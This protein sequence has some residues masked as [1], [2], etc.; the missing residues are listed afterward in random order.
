[1]DRLWIRAARGRGCAHCER[2][3]P[4][5]DIETAGRRIKFSLCLECV[6]VWF[7]GKDVAWWED[8]H[9]PFADHVVAAIQR[10]AAREFEELMKSTKGAPWKSTE[11]VAV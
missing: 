7:P 3:Q 5:E 1:M 10:A 11:K 8:H 6:L 2:G 9:A 4:I